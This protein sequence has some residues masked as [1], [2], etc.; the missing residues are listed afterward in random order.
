[1]AIV[2]RAQCADYDK[3]WEETFGKKEKPHQSDDIPR[4]RHTDRMMPAELACLC[5]IRAIEKLGCDDRL[6]RAQILIQQA[7]ELVADY[8]DSRP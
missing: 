7:Q 3:G 2:T 1:M 5:A 8:V 4:R 6:T